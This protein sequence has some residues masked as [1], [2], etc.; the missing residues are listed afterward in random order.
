MKWAT[1][2]LTVVFAVL[3]SLGSAGCSKKDKDKDK[4][5][6]TT[7]GTPDKD[8]DK[9]NKGAP[10]TLADPGSKSVKQGDSVKVPITITRKGFEGDV[11]VTFEGLPKGVK[12]DNEGDTI[13]KGKESVTYT[14]KAD[15]KAPPVMDQEV[16]VEA[17][18]DGKKQ[19][20]TLKL[21][22]TKGS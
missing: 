2:I 3:L 1:A 16:T 21:T 7:S 22:V 4:D 18:G 15:S 9:D 10:F 17:A 8:K 6:G 19:K 20:G 12:V 11:K 13:P 5:K 14:L